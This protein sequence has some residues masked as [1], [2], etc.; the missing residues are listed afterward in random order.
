[1]KQLADRLASALV[2]EASFERPVEVVAYGLEIIINI[3]V[4]TIII[5]ITAYLLNIFPTVLAALI[6]AIIFRSL[7]GGT[8]CSNFYSCTVLSTS[9]FMAIGY[10]ALKVSMDMF[11]LIGVYTIMLL[12]TTAWA[13]VKTQKTLVK[14]K[15][16]MLK[17][18]SLAFLML[19][20]GI[21]TA[22]QLQ[23]E[24]ITATTMGLTWQVFSITPLGTYMISKADKSFQYVRKGVC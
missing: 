23:E 7:S 16:I 19:M 14:R 1:M 17:V 20:F 24:L 12:A 5:M 9:V 6:S 4:Q 3:T 8:H 13:P 18:S 10:L 15:A 21:S 2:R 11:L 22:I